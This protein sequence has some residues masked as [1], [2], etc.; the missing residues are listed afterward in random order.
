MPAACSVMFRWQSCQSS[1]STLLTSSML[2]FVR[3]RFTLG[4]HRANV[5]PLSVN[6]RPFM[7]DSGDRFALARSRLSSRHGAAPREMIT[8]HRIR[9]RRTD[10][11]LLA[12][13]WSWPS[14]YASFDTSARPRSGCYEEDRG[15]AGHEVAAAAGEEPTSHSSHTDWQDGP[16]LQVSPDAAGPVAA[17]R[18]RGM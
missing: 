7:N 15:G 13:R 5:K 3:C 16:G 17:G 10:S 1:S 6:T 4:F 11:I 12:A 2:S 18:D 14:R 9:A 8:A